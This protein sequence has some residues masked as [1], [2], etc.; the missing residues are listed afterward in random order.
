MGEN[1][2]GLVVWAWHLVLHSVYIFY[3]PLKDS[4]C[5]VMPHGLYCF[6][7]SFFLSLANLMG[8]LHSDKALLFLG[9][10]T[11]PIATFLAVCTN[12]RTREGIL[13]KIVCHVMYGVKKF[14]TT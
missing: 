2:F 10:G 1:S 8:S 9:G 6:V 11:S 7:F 14:R 4:L 3:C 5:H 13:S 12:L